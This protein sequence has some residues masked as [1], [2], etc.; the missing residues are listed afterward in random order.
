MTSG[1][2]YYIQNPEDQCFVPY[3]MAKDLTAATTISE[4]KIK[5][6]GGINIQL[7]EIRRNGHIR[8]HEPGTPH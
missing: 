4:A 6:C 5:H 3:G 8:F 2:F 1:L 7:L